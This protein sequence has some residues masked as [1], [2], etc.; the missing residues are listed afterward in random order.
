V[1]RADAAILVCLDQRALLES[2]ENVDL[3][4]LLDRQDPR[5]RREA[6]ETL[7]SLDLLER[8]ERLE[9]WEIVVPQDNRV[10]RDSLDPLASLACRASR[11]TE[12]IPVTR[13]HKAILDRLAGRESRDRLDLLDL[14]VPK[15]LVVRL[16]LVENQV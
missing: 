14:W 5:E 10:F 3:R 11:V 9:L 16:D 12:A 4:V 6:Q 2:W 1:P 7:D 15:V 13:E 8:L